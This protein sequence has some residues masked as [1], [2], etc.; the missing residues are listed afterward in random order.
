[1]R[2]GAWWATRHHPPPTTQRQ[3]SSKN[4]CLCCEHRQPIHAMKNWEKIKEIRTD[5]S[6]YVLH[7]TRG[8]TNFVEPFDVLKQIL[9][10]GFF[11]A[12][13]AERKTGPYNIPRKTIKGPYP[14]VC[15]TEQP[16][17][18]FSQS[19]ST[20]NYRYTEFAI[21]VKK[22]EL[23]SYGGR[24]VIYSD[25]TTFKQL[26]LP[27][28]YQ[29]LWANYDPTVLWEREYP[30][31]F[32]HEREWRTR[33]NLSINAGIGLYTDLDKQGWND[34]VRAVLEPKI[35]RKRVPIQLPSHNSFT[36][37][38]HFVVLV[39]T[40]EHKEELAKWITDNVLEI[41]TKGGYWQIYATSL[42]IV[43]ETRILCFE[44]IPQETQLGKIED[45]IQ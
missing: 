45:Y 35:Q 39:D 28:E 18:F 9:R 40:K 1:M 11:N 3:F 43:S 6:D 13:H 2:G 33:A 34:T 29:Y 4:A 44:E 23:F 22:D 12:T 36:S 37:D 26:Q 15:F 32:T 8:E 10:D 14:A 38:A 16:L 20:N 41:R 7:C 5:M 30:I 42:S 25:K 21:A 27:E 24:P 31:D 17:Q 19:V